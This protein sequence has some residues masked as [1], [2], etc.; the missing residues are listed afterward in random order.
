MRYR[1]LPDLAMLLLL[2]AVYFAAAKI[3]LALA[4]VHASATAVWPPTGIAL[5]ANLVWGYRV[6]PGILLGAFLVNVT[7]EGTIATSL[8]IAVGNTLE[9][10]TGAYLVNRFA[11]GREAFERAQDIARYTFL[12]G[13]V[14]TAVAATV[15]VTSLT[16]GG[17]AR[18]S[19]FG[20]IWFTWWLG[21][22]VGALVVAPLLILWTRPPRRGRDGRRLRESLL[23]LAGLAAVGSIVFGGWLPTP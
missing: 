2:A 7:T 22:A 12:A 19:D 16:L 17:F 9:G 18:W 14:S 15:G 11:R 4:F 23:L 6:W 21:D 10:L 20:G 3:G 5:A 13:M 1:S 8:G